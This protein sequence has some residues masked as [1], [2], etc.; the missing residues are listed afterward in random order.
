MLG[1]YTYIRTDIHM[2]IRTSC[3]YYTRSTI[4]TYRTICTCCTYC[5][6]PYRTCVTSSGVKCCGPNAKLLP[7]DASARGQ[8]LRLVA[9]NTC[10]GEED[11][12]SLHKIQLTCA[13]NQ[14]EGS[15][16]HIHFTSILSAKNRDVDGTQDE[17]IQLK[18]TSAES[19]RG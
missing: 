2:Y 12:A 9:I 13:R 19:Q 16:I 17:N 3:T 15:I 14:V 6:V 4:C 5:T 7:S 1:T 18:R 11:S 8:K 10:T